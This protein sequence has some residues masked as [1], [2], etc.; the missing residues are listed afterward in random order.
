M[1]DEVQKDHIFL[2]KS[3]FWTQSISLQ[4]TLATGLDSCFFF[5]FGQ[6]IILYEH[7]WIQH[8]LLKNPNML[9]TK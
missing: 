6:V 5:F 9:S 2:Q 4:K 7:V 1:P 8:V 3:T